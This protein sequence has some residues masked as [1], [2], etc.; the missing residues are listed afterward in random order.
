MHQH[1]SGRPPARASLRHATPTT[2]SPHL[3]GTPT[4]FSVRPNQAGSAP[5]DDGVA[6]HCLAPRTQPTRCG[7]VRGTQDEAACSRPRD[8]PN[9]ARSRDGNGIA[10]PGSAWPRASPA[11]DGRARAFR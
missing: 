1:S 6:L 9:P 5:A 10:A 3:P 8:I 7:V 11:E 2:P 4:P